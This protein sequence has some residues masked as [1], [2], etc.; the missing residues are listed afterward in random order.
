MTD[1]QTAPAAQPSIV[2][3]AW[4]GDNRPVL[5]AYTFALLVFLVATAISSSFASSS[6]VSSLMLQAS[7]IGVAALGQTFVLLGG[8]I[9]LSIPWVMTASAVVTCRLADG[10]NGALI[11]VI[12]VVLVMAAF[13]GLLNGVGVNI[14]KVSAIVMTLGMSGVIQGAVLLYTQGKGSPSAPP[15]LNSLSKSGWGPFTYL[16][17]IWFVLIIIAVVV[18]A[19]STYGRT[20][21]ATGANAIV[22]RLSGIRT[23]WVS[24]ATYMLSAVTAS[25]A[26]I[27]LVGYTAS[28]FL[29]MGNPYLFS[30]IAAVAVGGTSILGGQGGYLGTVAGALLITFLGAL[31]PVLNLT[32]AAL[33]IIYGVVIL[34]AVTAATGRFSRA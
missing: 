18:L 4:S 16:T 3:R 12:P 33:P 17:I 23:Q 21:Y 34:V 19:R 10:D 22:S 27:M 25:I 11:W 14:L 9:D 7:I 1:T 29:S 28:P 26:G 20:L 13:V 2:R 31:L 24:I 8:G 30:S 32:Q 5:L 15:A 6:S